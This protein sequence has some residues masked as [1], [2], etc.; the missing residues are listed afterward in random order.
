MSNLSLSSL[1][2]Q[3]LSLFSFRYLFFGIPVLFPFSLII[4]QTP[5]TLA[6]YLG[7]LQPF[8]CIWC[9]LKKNK[10]IRIAKES[11]FARV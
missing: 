3:Y 7:P 1:I 9:L 8:V 6:N 2:S 11:P 5:R 10:V 4:L